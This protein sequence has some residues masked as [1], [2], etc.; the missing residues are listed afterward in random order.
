[1]Y[2]AQSGHLQL[3]VT[4]IVLTK[5]N[6]I[7]TIYI[8]YFGCLYDAEQSIKSEYSSICGYVRYRTEY[9][10]LKA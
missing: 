10:L 1:M 6:N 2:P 8:V 3:V 5:S 4:M 9:I 7:F